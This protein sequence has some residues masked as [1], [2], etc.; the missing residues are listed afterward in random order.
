MLP[1]DQ[2]GDDD[3]LSA[4]VLCQHA[5]RM[6]LIVQSNPSRSDCCVVSPPP[7]KH[8]DVFSSAFT[9]ASGWWHLTLRVSSAR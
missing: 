1:V 4:A 8:G 7:L 9:I 5:D 6:L 3:P 2:L